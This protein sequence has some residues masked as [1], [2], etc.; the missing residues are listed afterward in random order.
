MSCSNTQ[1]LSFPSLSL[2]LSLFILSHWLLFL[3]QFSWPEPS[4]LTLLRH[5]ASLSH[6]RTFTL[7]LSLSL[8]LLFQST[9]QTELVSFS[10][11]SFAANFRIKNTTKKNCRVIPHSP[12]NEGFVQ[13]NF[14]ELFWL[15]EKRKG[16]FV[17]KAGIVFLLRLY[18]KKV[19]HLKICQTLD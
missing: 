8:I 10:F 7:S 14:F 11:Q 13:F 17:S 2:S 15:I 1:F 9:K 18:R 16:H 12:E 3:S 19:G 6:S 5:S 4:F